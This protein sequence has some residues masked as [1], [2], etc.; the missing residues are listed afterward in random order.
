MIHI[1]VFFYIEK[2]VSHENITTQK[3]ERKQEHEAI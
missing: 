2:T 3:I 1:L